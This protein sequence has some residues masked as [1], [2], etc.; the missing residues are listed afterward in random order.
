MSEDQRSQYRVSGEDLGGILVHLTVGE[1]LE[2]VHLINVSAAGSA[3]ALPG[4]SREKVQEL[5]LSSE[6][7]PALLIQSV[8]LR[9]PLDIL[10]RVAHLDELESGCVLGLSFKRRV[11]QEESLDRALLRVFNRRSAVRI[12]TDPHEPVVVTLQDFRGT[13]LT[14]GLMRDLSLT[15]MGLHVSTASLAALGSGV[16]VRMRFRLRGELLE[17]QGTVRYSRPGEA[18]GYLHGEKVAVGHLGIEFA[19][20]SVTQMA[21]AHPV[22]S[23]VMSRQLEMRREAKETEDRRDFS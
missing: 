19:T 4:W 6:E 12:E 16:P 17:V 10:C 9:E 15:G 23:W 14:R 18:R 20:D 5:L 13:E 1:R 21:L 7:P 3:V 2:Q 8:R 22:A 11:E